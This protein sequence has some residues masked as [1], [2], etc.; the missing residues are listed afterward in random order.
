VHTKHFGGEIEVDEPEVAVAHS[1][2]IVDDCLLTVE[3]DG[4]GAMFVVQGPRA[5]AGLGLRLSD[6]IVYATS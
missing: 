6:P 1:G 3:N 4:V 5:G 2:N